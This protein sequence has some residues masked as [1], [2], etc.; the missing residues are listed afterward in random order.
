MYTPLGHAELMEKASV[1]SAKVSSGTSHVARGLREVL[2]LA[3][4]L[5]H[6]MTTRATATTAIKLHASALAGIC[7]K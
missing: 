7:M 6:S 2:E 5:Q 3:L 1:A 4:Q